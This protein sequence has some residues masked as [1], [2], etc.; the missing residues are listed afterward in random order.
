MHSNNVNNLAGINTVKKSDCIYLHSWFQCGCS[1]DRTSEK[2]TFISIN[3]R[4][5]MP[6]Y[7]S[8]V[9]SPHRLMKWPSGC[10]TRFWHRR[11]IRNNSRFFVVAHNACLYLK[12]F[13]YAKSWILE[14]TYNIS[15]LHLVTFHIYLKCTSGLWVFV[16]FNDGLFSPASS[17]D[18]KVTGI[19]LASGSKKH[20][21]LLSDAFAEF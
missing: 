12:Y 20:Q 13:V 6:V 4:S 5:V 17:A 16:H 15:P 9:A 1:W 11:A 8:S 19:Q 18:K 10:K 3:R 7:T 2:P 21:G 14:E